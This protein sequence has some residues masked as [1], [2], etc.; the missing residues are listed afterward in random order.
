MDDP[1]VNLVAAVIKLAVDD[2]KGSNPR[3]P[4]VSQVNYFSAVDFFA[5]E[6]F[7]GW[8]DSLDLNVG[9]VRKH[10]NEIRA[11]RATKWLEMQPDGI[12][13]DMWEKRRHPMSPNVT[14]KP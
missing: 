5:G 6:R 13:I 12:K 1:F 3:G 10:V 7:E 2:V 4:Q 11:D 9:L 14:R 8:A